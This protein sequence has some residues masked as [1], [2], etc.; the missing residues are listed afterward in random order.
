[1]SLTL[2]FSFAVEFDSEQTALAFGVA[3]G[4][5]IGTAETNALAL[6]EAPG[7]RVDRQPI[8]CE[9]VEPVGHG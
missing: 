8:I 3:L 2:R 6:S 7:K 1:M 5:V 4:S 9:A